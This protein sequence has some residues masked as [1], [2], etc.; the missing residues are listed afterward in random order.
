MPEANR[1]SPLRFWKPD[2]LFVSGSQGIR[3][4]RA[5]YS[6]L[7]NIKPISKTAPPGCPAHPMRSRLEPEPKNNGFTGSYLN[8]IIIGIT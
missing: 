3:C 7:L 6:K 1:I 2:P 4:K 5:R 8:Y